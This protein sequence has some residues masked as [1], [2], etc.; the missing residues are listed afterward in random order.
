[1]LDPPFIVSLAFNA[2]FL[3][4]FLVGCI[5]YRRN[6]IELCQKCMCREQKFGRLKENEGLEPIT[7]YSDETKRDSLNID[8]DNASNGYSG[9][10]DIEASV[11]M[12]DETTKEAVP[13]H[14]AEDTG[15]DDLG[16]SNGLDNPP[17]DIDMAK[18]VDS[19]LDVD[20]ASV[21]PAVCNDDI[22]EP[23]TIQILCKMDIPVLR[24]AAEELK[25]Q[26]NKLGLNIDFAS[27]GDYTSTSSVN[28]LL[29]L[30]V[31][32]S[33]LGTDAKN[34]LKGLL[35]PKMA[36]LLILHPQEKHALPM[37]RSDRILISEEFS[38]L[39]GIFDF[40][41][42]A[43]CGMYSCDMNSACLQE[44]QAFVQQCLN[45]DI[46]ADMDPLLITAGGTTFKS[47]L[48]FN[49]PLIICAI[50]T[51]TKP[52]TNRKR[53]Q[54]R[55]KTHLDQT[56]SS[57]TNAKETTEG[58]Q[59]SDQ[60][61]ATSDSEI[62]LNTSE[63]ETTEGKQ[64]FDQQNAPSDLEI[65]SNT[66]GKETTNNDEQNTVIEEVKVSVD[67]LQVQVYV[68]QQT[69]LDFVDDLIEQL[70]KGSNLNVD[71]ISSAVDIQKGKPLLLVCFNLSRLGT[72]ALQTIKGL[73]GMADFGS[74]ILLV[75]Y[76]KDEHA[77]PAQ[78]SARVLVNPEFNSLK[79]IYDIACVTGRGVYPCDMNAKSKTSIM[80]FLNSFKNNT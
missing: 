33:R 77:L 72:D 22:Q 79:G 27:V 58:K 78:S 11:S 26:M 50:Y 42:M 43:K 57:N 18:E 52:E 3:L 14:N 8:N 1:M 31:H 51:C 71:K 48:L 62:S 74:S 20:D 35:Y 73:K 55:P 4:L 19:T 60:H 54:D 36:A 65:S 34:A 47:V 68:P 70:E 21:I 45:N 46:Q 7:P 39:G 38:K 40:A 80:E 69:G 17:N 61:N 5:K 9:S 56:T 24:N 64:S 63:K 2:F 41:Y 44:L 76:H 10:T 32:S 49:L 6:V 29:I 13:H 37:N 28:P 75:F 30:C 67:P 23:I 53:S 15:K 59:S 16:E 66:S 12:Q 25:S